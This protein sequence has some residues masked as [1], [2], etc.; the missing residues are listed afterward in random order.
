RPPGRLEGAFHEKEG[1]CTGLP[2]PTD[3]RPEL[4]LPRPDELQ[5]PNCAEAV[6]AG[7]QSPTINLAMSALALEVVRRIVQGRCTW[8]QVSLDLAAGT[9]QVTH[10]T[11]E[12]VA[13]V[14]GMP[15]QALVYKTDGRKG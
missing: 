15:A 3:Q 4:L 10:A 1:I 12:V 11:P 9:M 2:R 6:A 14:T 5:G 13:Q 8:M 7:A